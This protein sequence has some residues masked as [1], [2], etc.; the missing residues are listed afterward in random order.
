MAKTEDPTPTTAPTTPTRAATAN[1][2]LEKS[3]MSEDKLRDYL[4]LATTELRQANRRVR[5]LEDK[6]REPIAIVGMGCRFPGGADTPERFWR[7][8]AE[9]IDAMGEFPADRGWKVEELYDADPDATGK[10]YA[11]CGAFLDDAEGFD[12]E[13]FGISPREALA[14]D[15]QQRIL[16]ETAWETFENAGIDP[17]ALHGSRTGV[18][19]GTNG[20]DYL[21]SLNDK[22]GLEKVE[23]Y[24]GTGMSA[25]V[26]SGRLSYSFGF[27]G[28]AITVD[29]ACSSSLVAIHLALQA[30]RNGECDLALAGGA[31]VMATP[32]VFTEFSRQRGLATD[33]RSKAFAAA[34]DGVGW[35]EG[36]GLILLERLSDARRAGHRILALVRGSAVNQDGAS[37]GL[38]APNGPSQQRV[39]RQALESAQLTT[40]DIDVVEA[41]G[42]GTALGDP[43][44]AQALL[45]TY[46]QN[47]PEDKPLWLGSVKSNIGHTQ[48]AAGIAG[49]IKM[50]LALRHDV[51]PKTLHVDEPTPHVE[52]ESGAVKLLTEP[53]DWTRN[54]HPR[55]AAVSSFGISGTNAHIIIEEPP[56]AEESPETVSASAEGPTTWLISA[57][58]PDALREQ[59]DR[60]A[61]FASTREDVDIRQT[62]AALATTRTHFEQRA[63]VIGT[64]R[65]TLLA[66]LT[67]LAA[68][69]EHIALVRGQ[70]AAG[71]TAFLFSGQGSQR[72]GAGQELYATY[73]VFAAAVDEACAVFDPLLGRSL[74]EV[75][76]SESELLNQTLYT[77]PALF[78]LHTALFRLLESAGVRP[79]Y[80]VGHSIGELSAAHV[81]EMLSL[82]D[83]ATLVYHRARLMD[84]ITTP[85]TMLAIQADETT[86]RDL[87]EDHEDE[88]SLAAINAP[89]STVLSGDPE[90]LQQ[91]AAQ[92]KGRGVKNKQLTV[93]HAFHSPHQ[94]QILYEFQQIAESITYQ[95]PQI[96]IVSTLT[97]Q[98]ADAQQMSTGEYWTEQLRHTVRH[99]DA[100]TTLAGL[101]TNHYLELTSS[102]TLTPLAAETLEETPAALIP[103]LRNGQPEP[104]TLLRAIATLHATGTDVTWPTLLGQPSNSHVDLPT[105]PFQHQRYWL[106][107]LGPQSGDPASLGLGSADHAFLRAT[108]RL[109]DGT[110]LFTGRLSLETH[111]WLAHHAVLGTVI[112]PG[113]AF[114]DLVLHAA[115]RVGF[116]TI[117][118]LTL[119]APLTFGDADA[120]LLQVAV[121]PADEFGRRGVTVH[122]RPAESA[123]N[124]STGQDSPS[125]WTRH[126]TGTL[127]ASDAARETGR[128]GAWLPESATALDVEGLYDRLPSIGIAFGPAFRGLTAAYRSGDT[129]YAEVE[130]PE[131][132]HEDT[133]G[134]DIHPALLDAALHVLWLDA[135]PDSDAAAVIRLPFA[136][137]GVSLHAVGATRARVTLTRVGDGAVSLVI[138][139]PGDAP[140]VSVERLTLRPVAAEQLTPSQP[141][142]L[143]RDSLFRVDWVPV[144]AA[145]ATQSSVAVLGDGSWLEPLGLDVAARY[146][147]LA[148]LDAAVGTGSAVPGLVIVLAT[149]AGSA[150]TTE[151]THD[152]AHR[153]LAV[154][155]EFLAA[156]AL[157]A[158][159]LVIVTRGA[160]PTHAAERADD[161]ASAAV[162]GLIRSAQ[163]ENPDR[164]VLLDLD[165]DAVPADFLS[166]IVA[167]AITEL[168]EPQLAARRGALFAPRL[169]RAASTEPLTPPAGESDW[170]LDA[171]TPGTLDALALVPAPEARAPLAAGQVRIAVRATGLNFRDV[172]ITLGMYPERAPL[173]SEAAGVVIETAEDVTGLRPG[174]RVMGLFAGAAGPVAVTDQRLLAPVPAGWSFAQAAT[175]PIVFLTAYYALT[176]LVPLETHHTILIHA[177]TGGV[178][179]AAVQLARLRGAEIY[180]TAQPAKWPVLR[181]QGLD[182]AHIASTRTLDFEQFILERTRGRGVD[183]VL[184]SLAREF[185][186]ASLRLL[187]R[188]GDFVE[189]GKTDIREPEVVAGEHPGVRY[190]AFDMFDA[191][192]DRI[193]EMFA[194]LSALFASGELR[195]LPVTCWEIGRAGD[196]LRFLSQAR[197]TG[198]LALTVP[199]RTPDPEGTYLITGGTGGLGSL[200]ARHL[201]A[202][203]GVRRLLLAGRRGPDSPGAAELAEELRALGAQVEIRACDAADRTALAALLADIPAE[204]PLTGVVHT[205]G[206][207]ADGTFASLTPERV[208][209]VMRAKVDAAWNLHELTA[210]ADL[211]A[212]VLF[213]SSAGVLGGPGQANYAAANTFLDALA[214]FRALRGLPA[215]SL[216]WGLWSSGANGM[217]R[218]LGEA[219]RARMSRGGMIPL[220][221]EEGL[222]L[223]DAVLAAPD[224]PVLVPARLDA[225]AL[226]AR[227]DTVAPSILRALIRPGARRQAA[228]GSGDADSLRTR[229]AGLGAAERDR[230]LLDVVRGNAAA[231]LGHADPAGIDPQRAF[232]EL[233]FDSLTAVEFRNR[234]GAA[235]GLRLPATLAFDY[236]SP[237]ALVVYLRTE[238]VDEG[239]A[240]PARVGAATAVDP[241]RAGDEIAIIGMS[242]RFPGQATSPE[243]LWRLVA[244]G[245]DAI[246]AFPEGRGWDQAA[247]YDPDPE[248]L[249]KTYA[250]EGGFLYDA[251]LFDAEFF[252]IN[253]REALAADPQQR[254]LLET[255]WEVFEDAGLDPGTLRGSST[256]VFAGVSSQSY[257]TTSQHAPEGTDGYLL[258]GTTTSVASGR[259]AYTFGLEGPA[260]TVD[261]ACSSSLVAMHLAAQALRNGECDFAL[262]GGAAIMATPT[263]FTEFSRQRG[264]APDGRSKPFAA[265]A[266]GVGWGEGAGLLL[267]ERLGEAQRNGHRILAVIKGSAINQDGASNGLTAPNG[268]SQQRVIRQALANAGLEPGDVD[269]VEAHG[270]GTALGDPIE[271]QALLATY[272]RNR[273]EDK[274]LWLGSLKSNIGHTQAAAGVGGVIK[275]VMALNHETLPK[276]LHVDEPSPHVDWT[277]GAVRLLT[278]PVD[279]KR[280]GHPR[281]A[282]VS[283][284]GISGTNAHVILEEAPETGQPEAGSP[285]PPVSQ[286]SPTDGVVPWVLSAR[287]EIALR[288]QAARL[289][290]HVLAHPDESIV[291]IGHTLAARR[292]HF[293]HRAV[294]I[295]RTREELVGALT[296]LA[297]G[298]PAANLVQGESSGI[299]SADPKIV[300]VFPGQ[301]S[302]W[303][304][305]ARDLYANQPAF[306][307]HLDTIA[308]HLDPLTGW[309]LIDALASATSTPDTPDHVQPLLYAVMSALAHTWH[310][311]GI[312]PHAVIGHSQGEI[313]A[314]HT[315]GA[316]SPRHA[317][318]LIAKRSHALIELSGHGAMASIALSAEATRQLP[319]AWDEDVFVSAMNGPASTVVSGT[320]AALEELIE[321][322]QGEGVRA[323]RVQVDYAS[324]SPAVEQLRENLLDVLGE[325]R[326]VTTELGFYSTL[327][328]GPIDT[329]SLDAQYWYDNL[330]QPVLFEQA[331]RALLD[332]GHRLFI[333]VSPHPI[334]VPSIQATIDA[335]APDRAVATGTLR[336]DAGGWEQLLT[337]VAQAY[338]YGAKPDWATLFPAAVRP[339]SL[340]TYPFQRRRYWA[341][342]PSDGADAAGLGLAPVGH[343]LLGAL[344]ELPGD[345]SVLTGRISLRNRPWLGDHAVHDTVLLPGAALVETAHYAA[346]LAGAGGVQ[347]LTIQEPLVIPDKGAV[348]LR[349]HVGAADEDSRR[350]VAVYSRPAGAEPGTDWVRHASGTLGSAADAADEAGA[351]VDLAAWPPAG[352]QS[353]DVSG[354][355]QGLAAI[356]LGYGP[357]FQGLRSAWR[358]G[359]TV[360][361]EIELAEEQHADAARF[362]IHPALLD[363]ALHATALTDLAQR[364]GADGTEGAVLLPFA[365]SGVSLAASGATAARI[366]LEHTGAD[367]VAL[368]I[369]DDT[370]TVLAR[371][372]SLSVRPVSAAR[373]DAARGQQ[374]PLYA[375][376]WT[377]R[378]S[379]QPGRTPPRISS[380]STSGR[381]P[382]S[383]RSPQCTNSPKGCCDGS[384]S[385]WPTRPAPDGSH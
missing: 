73:P 313:A 27:E 308:T 258:T 154:A 281:R 58:S 238:L 127:V 271:A 18:F 317:A 89:R 328:G 62:A 220:A 166:S 57:K 84:Q 251:D 260:V 81:A 247:L 368:T 233:G 79:D 152:L 97:G 254:L 347:E 165:D 294:A 153:T 145:P 14:T 284:F 321:Y 343:P 381:T 151:A 358:Q 359:S 157:D 183:I 9:N 225:A 180:A 272:G 119:Q 117:D 382:G 186:D 67:A 373:L 278:E 217:A 379:P 230:V 6:Q 1:R 120:R 178:G 25:S 4:K 86:A 322:C 42:T 98:L 282:A 146:A 49:I 324:H 229:L 126:A 176:D 304:G 175:T 24:L 71:K 156:P 129:L 194:A 83:A 213:S 239:A 332:D 48:A 46:G 44:E 309:S 255:A 366:R 202:N 35:G 297:E 131:D 61:E 263:I 31:T 315:T 198:K 200:V 30:L 54:G 240:V 164:L 159:R 205:A 283:S 246:G 188:G 63:A 7:L 206:V 257:G 265:A 110:Q 253:P 91:I 290:A 74:R 219:D 8:V 189:M 38:T 102:P 135:E 15:P 181:A 223:L 162:W 80:L 95:A 226:R 318:T 115:H 345:E 383:I 384:R 248:A 295:G 23:G 361:A 385:T 77:Q 355:Y 327:T 41:H 12:A 169:V 60:L 292:A 47:R 87:I 124:E 72:V 191:G 99:A 264:V 267:L 300:F 130:L 59:A 228:I 149:S 100:I 277:A 367:T 193:S 141:T 276:T 173:G 104:E 243:Q 184:D 342:N 101:G 363:A 338:V 82:T 369:A 211:A 335:H 51:L 36:S 90:I 275:T 125:E 182:D 40:A 144:P 349:V 301:G 380:S 378:R 207:L 65:D 196:A 174:D 190:Q 201:V 78:T 320:P 22:R 113:T 364:S 160:V 291:E 163:T 172:L 203:H 261:T 134:F 105:Y 32:A 148:A 112:L 96:P 75:M 224:A 128:S 374:L 274:P 249:G 208:D 340:P 187:P 360:Y 103:T 356:G 339:V 28:A 138:T 17:T 195:P 93:S 218:T 376:D 52:W 158:S 10:T 143:T 242:C 336:R 334:L 197:H 319:A 177:A 371:V 140:I 365:W 236:P 108:T 64:D 215:T 94:D 69:A 136:W 106:S 306:R 161:L 346:R 259:I 348:D 2:N 66:G 330:R 288:E 179:M 370:G 252:G 209:T 53:V 375:I 286:D 29:T 13:F 337:S 137:E 92:L 85:G 234:L 279:W 33:G 11:R 269:A 285:E 167:S 344:T 270:T 121:E 142:L 244:E 20:Q 237:A 21:R 222:A 341:E 350:P 37:N 70:V 293:D 241:A 88:I 171:P 333:E 235:T 245:R 147:D 199:H 56:A 185:V 39:I 296:A 310:S 118:D 326:P 34:A 351:P 302:Q 303:T 250:V 289:A 210:D 16:L 133:S 204:H 329:A 43:I 287:S 19:A 305:M 76:F 45:A 3:T 323:R 212:F 116:P 168:D 107:T 50:V 298:Q 155:Q 353:V 170:K 114:I 221:P 377:L 123:D 216:A 331:T 266:D 192:P 268:P 299:G 354:L 262:A 109:P 256:G 132:R 273:S 122:S 227:P 111:P 316:L 357:A 214:R 55:R 352:A 312:H 307:E 68:D 26:F 372:E 311:L 362:G 280:N 139:D 150:D 232:Q 5:A 314:A 325:V 231:V